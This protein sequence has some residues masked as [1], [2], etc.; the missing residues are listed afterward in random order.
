MEALFIFRRDLRL[1]DN[2]ALTAAVK[3]NKIIYPIFILDPRQVGPGNKYR[4]PVAID[5]ML[6]S[7]S[8]LKGK[9]GIFRGKP[10][11]VIAKILRKKPGI[12]RIYFNADY[13]PFAIKRDA[14]IKQKFPEVEV[15]VYHDVLLHPPDILGKPY[16][17]FSAY[18]RAIRKKAV[19]KPERIVNTAKFKIIG[20][21]PVNR[22]KDEGIK[23]FNASEYKKKHDIPGDDATSHFSAYLKFGVLSPR[24]IYHKFSKYSEFIRQL[25]WRDFYTSVVYYY[26]DILEKGKAYNDKFYVTGPRNATYLKAWEHG[27]TGFP[28][29]D[30]GMRQL[31]KI[32]WMHNRARLITASFLIKDLLQDWREGER[33]FARHLMDYDP[34]V[35]NGNWQWVA[36]TGASNMPYFRVFNPW[37]QSRK[38]DREGK[39]IKEWIPE[40]RDVP[41]KDLHRWNDVWDK[42]PDVK[43]PKPIIDHEE[44]KKKYLKLIKK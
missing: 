24:E 34:A 25:Y 8:N 17:V 12:T 26:P 35:N 30:A 11:E 32:G 14:E 29:V 28:I 20:S 13:T 19:P 7:L 40:L 23:Q 10:V 9:V 39:Y 38:F 31:N 4:S 2:T 21:K 5:F 36:G 1:T 18:Y 33:Y 3:E 42:Y 16:A 22:K 15:K 43:Y 41:A 44:Q 37:L 27:E 6:Q